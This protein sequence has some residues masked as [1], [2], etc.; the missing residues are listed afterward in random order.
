MKTFTIRPTRRGFG[1]YSGRTIFGRMQLIEEHERLHTA[2][3]HALHLVTKANHRLLDYDRVTHQTMSTAM[4]QPRTNEEH[5]YTALVLAGKKPRDAEDMEHEARFAPVEDPEYKKYDN[6]LENHLGK[7]IPHTSRVMFEERFL[8]WYGR[9]NPTWT[10][11]R[12]ERDYNPAMDRYGGN[13][14]ASNSV[15]APTNPGAVK[16][17][18]KSIASRAAMIRHAIFGPSADQYKRV[19]E[20]MDASAAQSSVGGR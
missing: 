11:P 2:E 4:C 10:D 15:S 19:A 9:E 5:I 14:Y 3:M 16:A 12:R 8:T 18:L 7:P 13:R 6:I 1:V 20:A 17:W